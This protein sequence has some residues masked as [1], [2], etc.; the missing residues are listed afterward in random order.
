MIPSCVLLIPAISTIE[1]KSQSFPVTFILRF[2]WPQGFKMVLTT[3][4]DY[5]SECRTSLPSGSD[6][7]ASPDLKPRGTFIDDRKAKY[8]HPQSER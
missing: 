7:Q 1:W 4:L 3:K 6:I 8:K 2:P 5:L